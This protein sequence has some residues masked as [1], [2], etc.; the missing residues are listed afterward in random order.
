MK[1]LKKL[2]VILL[3]IV[4]LVMIACGDTATGD[5]VT[6]ASVNEPYSGLI[7][8]AGSDDLAREV[9]VELRDTLADLD[10]YNGGPAY[11][12]ALVRE[13]TEIVVGDTDR[14]ASVQAMNKLNSMIAK[15]PD[16]FHWVF[17]YRDGRL[18]IV[19][20]SELAYKF[21]LEDF[22]DRYFDG[23]AITVT[24]GMLD[25]KTYTLADYEALF[26]MPLGK[27]IDENS[28]VNLAPLPNLG[29]AYEAGQGAY[30][31]IKRD[32]EIGDFHELRAEL[33]ARGFTYYTGNNIGRNVF[34]TYVTKTQIVHMMFL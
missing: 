7:V 32:M 13:D 14:K 21:A 26:T 30:T 6:I 18:A 11:S 28:L 33:E 17:C 10:L 24:D 15:S 22:F 2:S 12:A 4:A 8:F 34:A 20:N 16:D 1:T 27:G 3:V 23:N 31:Y 5:P 19:A 9:A 29:T 25:S